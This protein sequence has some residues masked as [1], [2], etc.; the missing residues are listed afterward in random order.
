MMATIASVVAIGRA[1]GEAAISCISARANAGGGVWAIGGGS[2]GGRTTASLAVFG[3]EAVPP[4]GSFDLRK[5]G[6]SSDFAMAQAASI[7]TSQIAT[8]SR[9]SATSR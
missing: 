2:G 8:D 3:I 5:Y 1:V 4:C 7:G 6:D 9:A